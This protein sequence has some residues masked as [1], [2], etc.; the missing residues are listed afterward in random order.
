M[1]L[2]V[3]YIIGQLNSPLIQLIDFIKQT[4]DAKISLERLG[5]I[6][7]KEDEES[8]DE[9]YTSEIPEK[10]IV[11][12]NMSFRYIGSDSF[13]FEDL[14]LNIPI[15]KQLQLWSQWKWKNNFIKIINEIL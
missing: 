6:H 10:D 7:D 9:Q 13:V 3:Q 4:Q 15:K 11:I 2:S 14:S 12:H 1:M 5:E 8:L